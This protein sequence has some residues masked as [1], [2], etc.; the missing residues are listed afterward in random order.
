MD[1]EA[2]TAQA[3]AHL[4]ISLEDARK[5]AREIP[6]IDARL[7]FEPVR[8]G[9][10]VMIGSDGSALYG[11]SVLTV[12]QLISRFRDGHRTD[13]SRFRLHQERITQEGEQMSREVDLTTGAEIASRLLRVPY[14]IL[15]ANSKD[16]PEIDA[17]YYAQPIR[18]GGQMLVGRDGSVMF[19]ISALSREDMIPLWKEGRRTDPSSFDVE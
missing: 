7:F 9:G 11:S 17:F 14:D 2:S 3:S 18:G 13:P 16:L 4:G 10:K 12:N 15:L 8:G 19:A 5:H 6:E 1:I